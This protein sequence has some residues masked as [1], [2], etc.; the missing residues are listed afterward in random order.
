MPVALG[1]VH[2]M[3]RPWGYRSPRTCG[4]ADTAIT[5]TAS[6]EM[7]RPFLLITAHSFTASLICRWKHDVASV[8]LLTG[9]TLFCLSSMR[10]V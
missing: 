5:R 10:L 7:R 2:E 4:D 8:S 3:G 9:V 6:P 1:L